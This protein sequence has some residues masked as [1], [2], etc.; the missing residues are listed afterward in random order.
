LIVRKKKEAFLLLKISCFEPSKFDQKRE[1]FYLF[2]QP[3]LLQNISI[4]VTFSSQKN[5]V[6]YLSLPSK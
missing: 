3:F 1:N 2:S 4:F 5:R 6:Y